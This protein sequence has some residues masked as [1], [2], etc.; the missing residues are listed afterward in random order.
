MSTEFHYILLNTHLQLLLA[1]HHK[2]GID[3]THVCSSYLPLNKPL[4]SVPKKEF[5]SHVQWLV[6]AEFVYSL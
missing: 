2:P 5:E 6:D 3:I 4:L 1:D